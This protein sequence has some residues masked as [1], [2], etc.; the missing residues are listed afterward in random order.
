[1]ARDPDPSETIVQGAKGRLIS[2]RGDD[3]VDSLN[4]FAVG[5]AEGVH[6]FVYEPLRLPAA[7][8][9]HGVT[10]RRAL[11]RFHPSVCLFSLGFMRKLQATQF[12]LVAIC[13]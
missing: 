5:P 9:E 10:L 2:C 8:Q 12:A 6:D 7:G 1:M 3:C 11:L 4:R 13:K